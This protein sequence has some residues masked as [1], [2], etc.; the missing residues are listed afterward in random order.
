MVTNQQSNNG[1]EQLNNA[2]N[3]FNYKVSKLRML[4]NTKKVYWDGR[5]RNRAI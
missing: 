2:R 1:N 4:G 3:S 5:R